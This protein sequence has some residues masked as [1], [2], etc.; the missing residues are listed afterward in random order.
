MR[1]LVRHELV[2]DEVLADRGMTVRREISVER[3]GRML[4]DRTLG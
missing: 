1:R 3:G 4:G 2:N